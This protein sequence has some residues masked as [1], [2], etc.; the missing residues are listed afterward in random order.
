[1]DGTIAA[2]AA[3]HSRSG[4]R[5]A[6]E[7]PLTRIAAGLVVAVTLLVP[8]QF[9]AGGASSVSVRGSL[10]EVYT[11]LAAG[12]SLWLVGRFIEKRSLAEVGLPLDRRTGIIVIGF[13]IGAAIAGI[14]IGILAATGSY[15]VTGNADLAGSVGN[16]SLLLVFELGSAALQAILFYGI[17][18]RVLAEWLGRW[19]AIA[20]AVVL[21]GAIHL[22]GPNA[23][24]FS[25]VVVG[26]SGGV[27]LA[28]SYLA[29]K[30]LWL[31][32][33]I[34]WGVNFAFADILGAIPSAHHRLLE[35]RLSGSELLSGGAAGAEAGGATLIVVAIAVTLIAWWSS[36]RHQRD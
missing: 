15:S 25:A 31:P 35:G 27:L 6:L 12:L 36:T 14:S 33:G 30:G 9:L 16:L 29:T 20:L 10:I 23:T 11:G 1:M 2:L 3:K 8:A 19:P 32:M 5:R 34:L 24:V 13:A 7:F 28:V 21:F 17:V 18:F 22:T 4:L 26:L